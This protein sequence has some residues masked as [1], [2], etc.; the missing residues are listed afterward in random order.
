MEEAGPVPRKP[1]FFLPGVP[2]HLVQRGNNRAPIFFADRDRRVYLAW[3]T[4]AAG[5]FGCAVH[6]YV[7]MGNQKET[8]EHGARY[9]T[10]TARGITL[11][12]QKPRIPGASG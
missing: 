3:L 4:E 1:R 10:L 12:A 8:D 5:R 7:L 2:A 11:T 9:Y 6:A